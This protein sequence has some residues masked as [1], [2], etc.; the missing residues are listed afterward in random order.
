MRDLHKTLKDAGDTKMLA[1]IECYSWEDLLN[2]LLSFNT[3]QSL[4]EKIPKQNV[5]SRCSNFA[6]GELFLSGAVIGL[7]CED[8]IGSQTS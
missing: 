1:Y 6:Y 3:L 4:E 7:Y 8:T 2:L 5:W